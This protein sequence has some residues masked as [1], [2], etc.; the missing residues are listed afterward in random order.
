[1]S[2]AA[3]R[4]PPQWAKLVS[5]YQVTGMT[6]LLQMVADLAKTREMPRAGN[7]KTKNLVTYLAK[8]KAGKR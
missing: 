5:V 1:V 8:S 3:K 2:Y 6:Y 7:V 4:Y